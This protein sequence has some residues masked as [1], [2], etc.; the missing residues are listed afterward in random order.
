MQ[1]VYSNHDILRAETSILGTFKNNAKNFNAGKYFQQ[2]QYFKPKNVCEKRVFQL[3]LTHANKAESVAAGAYEGFLNYL[4]YRDHF[5]SDLK[6]VA[7][8][9][10][11]INNLLSTFVD[12]Q[13]KHM[14]IDCF[15]LIGL[16]GKIVLSQH[17][18]NGDRNIIELN[19]SC[20]FPEIIPAFQIKST[21]FLNPKLICID[22]FIENVSEIHR[23]LENANSSKETIILFVRGLSNDVLNTL[24]INYDRG[25]LQVI[26]AIVKYDL[27]GVNLL[28]D[29]AITNFS[30]VVSSNKGQLISS[31]NIDDYNRVDSVDVTSSGV[32]IENHR[33]TKIIDLHTKKLQE[34]IIN[35]NNQYEK[36]LV[37]KRIQ[38]LGMN[39]VTIRLHENQNNKNKLF[40]IDRALR[41][42]KASREYG[43]CELNNKTYPYS[44]IMTGIFYA[45][46]FKSKISDLGA[47][48]SD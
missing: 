4:F 39:R 13:S 24:K 19:S 23:V 6:N 2:L 5:I 48:I 44:G 34:K 26:P 42:V 32:L 31:I 1:L 21:K 45:K 14:L 28:N 40:E 29:I 12:E 47:I 27:D 22:G 17:P 3:L 38:N 43:I 36:D 33:A 25:S 18:V 11:N 9:S 7:L 37:T 35:S 20:Y 16:N 15:D 10:L 30:D 8:T 46:Q 41:A